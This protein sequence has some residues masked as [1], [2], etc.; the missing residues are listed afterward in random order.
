MTGDV[1]ELLDRITRDAGFPEGSAWWRYRFE[2]NEV[3]V[4]EGEQGAS[5][6]VVKQGRLR[7][8]GRVELEQKRYVQPGICDLQEGDLFGEHCLFEPGHRSASVVGL[9]QGELLEI[10]GIRLGGYLDLHPDLG[11]VLLKRMFVTSSRRLG[12][13]NQ[14]VEHLFAWGLKAHG[15]DQ[16]L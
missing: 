9:T 4:R 1:I 6:Y 10:D 11:Y 16:Y 8:T 12:R 13:A 2:P 5:L 3:I 7:V 15:I 14:R